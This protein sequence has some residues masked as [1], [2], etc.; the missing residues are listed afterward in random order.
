MSFATIR[1]V[2]ET[3]ILAAYQAMTPPVPV[4]FQ[5]VQETPPGTGA[6]TEYVILQVSFP[7]TTAPVLCLEESNIELVRGA[8]QVNCYT[9][10]EQGMKRLE[11]MAAVCMS[12][13][14]TLKAADPAVNACVGEISGPT[15]LLDSANP[16][17][18]VVLSA[19]FTAKG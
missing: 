1:A 7:T 8:V 19:S 10:R 14:N 3:N 12:T 6:A 17:A 9:P 15:P 18:Q 4:M 11:S 5:N 16:L 2:F 13:L